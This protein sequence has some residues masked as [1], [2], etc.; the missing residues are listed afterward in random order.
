MLTITTADGLS[1]TTR[2]VV[3]EQAIAELRALKRAGRAA[4]RSTPAPARSLRMVR[5]RPLADDPVLLGRQRELAALKVVGSGVDASP[6]RHRQDRSPPAARSPT[7]P[8]TTPRFR[9][10][11]VA[12]GRLLGQWRDELAARRARPRAA[13][14]GAQRRGARARRRTARS[15]ARSARFDRALGERARRRARAPTACSTATPA[16]LAGDRLAPADRRRGA[17]LRQPRHRRP[18]GARAACAS[19]AAA[20]CWLLTATPRGKSAEHLDVLVGL[21]LGD[22]AMIRERLNTREAGDLLDELNAHRLRVNYGPHLVRVT[23]Q[24]MQAWMPDVRPAQPLAIDPDAALA[25]LLEAIR[26]R[27]PRRLP[28]AARA[29]AR[30]AG[31]SSPAARST[32]SALAEL[33][34][35]AGR[36]ARQ[37]RRLRRRLRRPRDAHALQAP[38]SP[39]RSPRRALV[40]GGDARRRRR[41]AAAARH[42]RPDDRRRRRRGAGARVRRARALPAPARRH[43]ARAPRR[44]GARRRRLAHRARDFEALKRRFSAGEFPVLCLS[45]DRPRGPQPPERLGDRATS[46][47]RGCQTGLEQRV[48]RAARPGAARGAVQ[49]YIPYIKRRRH[50]AR[51]LRALARAAPSTTRSSTPSKASRAARVDDRHPARRDHRRGRRQPRT[52]PATPGPPPGCASPPSVFG[53]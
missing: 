38:R 52:T 24:D 4:S 46:T 8:P 36:R 44:R 27:R 19:A 34:R 14:A 50:R 17:A 35:V 42:H 20:D 10:L 6:G 3:A 29:A 28:A 11:V 16:E 49:T 18:P 26:Q 5:A 51:R 45:P 40:R 22:E 12:E 1:A 13:A 21:A 48:G 32:R 23:R 53:A 7:A 25:E 37:R 31:R 43:A 15:P 9:A 47:C 30:A 39:R 2:R 33:A 41:P